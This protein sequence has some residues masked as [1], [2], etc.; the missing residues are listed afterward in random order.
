MLKSKIKKDN[1][2]TS[3]MSSKEVRLSDS[4]DEVR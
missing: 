2:K 4:S 1:F 3:L